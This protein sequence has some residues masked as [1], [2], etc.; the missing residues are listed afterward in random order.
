ML[1]HSKLYKKYYPFK[2]SIC[3]QTLEDKDMEKL[4]KYIRAFPSWLNAW[5]I[6]RSGSMNPRTNNLKRECAHLI[7]K[8]EGRYSLCKEEVEAVNLVLY[9]NRYTWLLN[10]VIFP[11]P[12]FDFERYLNRAIESSVHYMHTVD[13]SL[14]A[15]YWRLNVYCNGKRIYSFDDR[16]GDIISA[17]QCA[18]ADTDSSEGFINDL[19]DT[20]QQDLSSVSKETLTEQ[21]IYKL[22]QLMLLGCLD[23]DPDDF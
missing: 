23:D 3:I 11:F 16:A 6:R 8:L 10:G 4:I 19:I 5:I 14:R 12:H 21:E 9:A 18:W 15:G 1:I 13:I 20:M 17:L 7:Q 22:K 2:Q